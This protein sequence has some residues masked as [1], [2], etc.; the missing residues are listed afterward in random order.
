MLSSVPGLPEQRAG[1]GRELKNASFKASI[2]K[3]Q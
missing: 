1:G 2:R 3:E